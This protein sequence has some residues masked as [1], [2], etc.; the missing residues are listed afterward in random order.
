MNIKGIGTD[1]TTRERFSKSNNEFNYRFLTDKEI[2]LLD[3]LKGNDAINFIAGRW[4]SKEAIVKASNKE[5]TFSTISILKGENGK[6]IVY[7]NDELMENIH[8]SISHENTYSIAFC[9]IENV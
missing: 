8:I 2:L 4:A 7:I 6:P 1:I 9:V 3:E 5:V